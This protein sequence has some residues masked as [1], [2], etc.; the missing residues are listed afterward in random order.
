[1]APSAAAPDA[2]GP[3]PCRYG[4]AG[5]G[6][7]A[8]TTATAAA[9]AAAGASGIVAG[10]DFC[11]LPTPVGVLAAAGDANRY[12][13]GD[14]ATGACVWASVAVGCAAAAAAA[15]GCCGIVT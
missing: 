5:S 6:C 1:M 11:L 10:S 7:T 4:G 12:G 2:V 15:G 8:A 14:A 9:A 3:A 13:D